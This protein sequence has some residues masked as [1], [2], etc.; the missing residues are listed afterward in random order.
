MTK[1]VAAYLRVSKSDDENDESLSL[2]TQRRRIKAFCEARDWEY[3]PEYIDDG[4]SAT[5]ARDAS[6]EWGRML[7]DLHTGRFDVIVAKDLDRLLRTLQDLIKL[8]ELKAKVATV[9]GEIDLESADGELRAT[10][11]AAVARFEIRRKTERAVA[12]NETRRKKGLPIVRSKI[13]GFDVDGVTQI[14]DEAAAVKKAFEDF[15]AGVRITHVA[16]DLTKKGFRTARGREWGNENIRHLLRQSKYK[17]VLTKWEGDEAKRADGKKYADE[18]YAADFEAIVSPDVF[19][20]VQ[21]KLDDPARK[22][23]WGVTPK[24][25]LTGIALC[26][27]CSDG[28]KVYTN[29]YQRTAY[30]GKDGVHREFEPK[31]NYACLAHKHLSRRAGPVEDFVEERVLW[32]LKQPDAAELFRPPEQPTIDRDALRTERVALDDRRRGLA[33]LFAD[34]VLDDDGVREESARLRGRIN[35]IDGLLAPSSS[36]PGLE[37]V[38]AEDVEEAWKQAGIERQRII[39][40]A[41]MTVTIMPSTSSAIGFDSSLI[42]VDWH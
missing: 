2:A 33:R 21:L 3:G 18:V 19:D 34:G 16:R 7:S 35:E 14:D 20:A 17:G 5:K 13:L 4:I 9:D 24:Y 26:G 27:K 25:L 30:T 11:L 29:F 28:T 23:A 1:R 40:Q 6:T 32:R 31:R 10:M 8:T 42:K 22:R 41:L 15:L 36:N 38:E 37:V 39:L 12:A